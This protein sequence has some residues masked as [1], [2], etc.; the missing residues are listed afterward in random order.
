MYLL[1][2]GMG[3]YPFCRGL[4]CRTSMMII[5]MIIMGG[6]RGA[7][8]G[9]GTGAGRGFGDRCCCLL[10]VSLNRKWVKVRVAS[11]DVGEGVVM[12]RG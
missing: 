1:G 11:V 7:G 3:L 8:A 6:I 10:R 2:A 9:A 12:D 5:I 4:A